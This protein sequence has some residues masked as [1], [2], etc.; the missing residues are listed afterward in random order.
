MSGNKINIRPPSEATQLRSFI[1][2]SDFK[3]EPTNE[4]TSKSFSGSDYSAIDEVTVESTAVSNYKRK[5]FLRRAKD[6]TKE[7]SA[8]SI[9]TGILVTIILFGFGLIIENIKDITRLEARIEY[10]QST[11]VSISEDQVTKDSLN[12]ELEMLK[13]STNYDMLLNKKDIENRLDII[14]LEIQKLTQH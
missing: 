12:F 7:N 9:I 3:S 10:A 11:L 4:E 2:H 6:W 8:L 5:P 1:Q 14:E 13:S